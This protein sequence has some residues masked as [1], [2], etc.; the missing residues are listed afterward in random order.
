M[1]RACFVSAIFLW[2]AFVPG[3]PRAAH[4]DA[5][6]G[7]IAAV[8]AKGSPAVVRVLAVRRARSADSPQPVKIPTASA[9]D[10][11]TMDIGSGFIIDPSGFIATNRHVVADAS[12][13][14]VVTADGVRYQA[15]IVGMPGG[16][17]MALLRID[18]GRKLPTL[19]FGDSDRMRVGDTVIAIGS[20]FGFDNTATAGII[21]A[22]NRDVSESPFDDYFQTDAATNHGN[23]GGPLLNLAG[24]VIGM[25]SLIVA[26]GSGWV[27]LTFAIPSNDLQFV[28]GRLMKAGEVK[29]GMLPIYTQP[30]TWTLMQALDAPSP[31]GALVSAM[32]PDGNATPEGKVQPGDIILSFN[33][34]PVIDSRD[35]ARQAAQASVGSDAALEIYR[36]GMRQTVHVTVQ[37]WPETRPGIHGSLQQVVG[38]ELA[39]VRLPGGKPVVTVAAIDPAGTAADSGIRKGDIIVEVQQTRI[40]EPNQALR[41]L[42]ARAETKH[43][44][45][46]VLVERGGKRSWMAIA[47]PD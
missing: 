30:V 38:L 7:R 12:S 15:T 37:V 40:F 26:P 46:A 4:A 2:L 24:E 27:G 13:V 16:V 19:A 43:D 8:V 39:S 11:V 25:N 47:L 22:V 23:S 9:L 45:A 42:D 33:G 17:D 1:D 28:F 18:A 32:R 5:E 34:K 3:S 35:L 41:I 20:P 31:G 29:A 6:P 44:F 10:E 14:F 36:D 21:S